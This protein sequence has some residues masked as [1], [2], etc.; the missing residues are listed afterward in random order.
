M[1]RINFL[2]VVWMIFHMSMYRSDSIVRL[3]SS[4]PA[5]SRRII[6]WRDLWGQG[7]MQ[8]PCHDWMFWLWPWCKCSGTYLLTTTEYLY[9]KYKTNNSCMVSWKIKVYGGYRYSFP[10][11]ALERRLETFPFP[12]FPWCV[13]RER[14]M[15]RRWKDVILSPNS[16]LFTAH[17]LM[18]VW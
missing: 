2:R 7:I 8:I 9:V 14:L 6:A 15:G 3:I 10:Y 4:C 17:V 11:T 13:V 12:P 18:G 1:C 5:G 16:R